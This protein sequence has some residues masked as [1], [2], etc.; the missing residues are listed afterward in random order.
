[1]AIP[2]FLKT[3]LMPSSQNSQTSPGS[4]GEKRAPE[5]LI[6]KKQSTNKG[7]F[8]GKAFLGRTEFKRFLKKAPERI[9]GVIGNFP[10][11]E[12]VAMEEE[13]FPKKE[14]GDCITPYEINRRLRNLKREVLYESD[15]GKKVEKRKQ[16]EYLE[17]LKSRPEENES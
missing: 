8:R 16:L 9:P 11:K 2:K 10:E 14:F 5:S 13:L 7:I 4:F 17:A 1:M 6:T 15:A 12:R 3:F